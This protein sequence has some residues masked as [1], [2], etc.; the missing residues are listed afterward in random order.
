[1]QVNRR[2]ATPSHLI[3][4]AEP[5]LIG[6]TRCT[7]MGLDKWDTTAIENAKKLSWTSE[8]VGNLIGRSKALELEWWFSG[9]VWCH[10]QRARPRAFYVILEGLIV[11]F[12]TTLKQGTGGDGHFAASPSMEVLSNVF[13]GDKPRQH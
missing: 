2:R 11:S 13:T 6:L 10:A 3:V 7:H 4:A 5:N 12:H 9:L 1:M 8:L